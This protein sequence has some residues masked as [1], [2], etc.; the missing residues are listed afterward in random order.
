MRTTT[1]ME[2]V[3][4]S[5]PNKTRNKN[6]LKPLCGL[7][8][9]PYFSALKIRWLIDNVPRV[10]QA[11]DA[12]RC[13]FGTVDT[14]LI[15]VNRSIRIKIKEYFTVIP[16]LFPMFRISQRASCILQMCQMHL[17]QC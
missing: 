5:V 15:W 6:Y 2:N 9:S 12:E 11:V 16:E 17:A 1:T 7:P 10:K 8:M 14:W 4:D 13:A 3:L